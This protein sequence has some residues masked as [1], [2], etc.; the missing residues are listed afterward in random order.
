MQSIYVFQAGP[1]LSLANAAPGKTLRKRSASAYP[2][3]ADGHP[4]PQDKQPCFSMECCII[5]AQT[6]R[7]KNDG[8]GSI[9]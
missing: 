3:G 6:Q 5:A 2:A 4:A 8:P 7:V 9:P 1:S